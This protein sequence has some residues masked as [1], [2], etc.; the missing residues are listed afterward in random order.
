MKKVKKKKRCVNW[1]ISRKK[2]DFQ[3]N[4]ATLQTELNDIACVF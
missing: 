3:E 4:L 1:K 2:K